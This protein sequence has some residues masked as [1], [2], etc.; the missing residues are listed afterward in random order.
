MPRL[1]GEGSGHRHVRLSLQPPR[2]VPRGPHVPYGCPAADP[3][4]EVIGGSAAL[5]RRARTPA[6]HRGRVDGPRPG[7]LDRGVE[8]EASVPEWPL[9]HAP[10][11]TGPTSVVSLRG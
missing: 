2:G 9:L 1:S 8:L 4:V 11:M 7:S 5:P 10:E 3:P 6:D